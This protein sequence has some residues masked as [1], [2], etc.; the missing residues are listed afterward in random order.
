MPMSRRRVL[1]IVEC[2]VPCLRHWFREKRKRELDTRLRNNRNKRQVLINA[3]ANRRRCAKN[4]LNIAKQSANHGYREV[5][6]ANLTK[7]YSVQSQIPVMMKAIEVLVQ[8]E[9]RTERIRDQY[10]ITGALMESAELM[11]DTYE[12]C[13]G[14][15]YVT[16]AFGYINR[17]QDRA[18]DASEEFSNMLHGSTRDETEEM[19]LEEIKNKIDEF[20]G[21]FEQERSGHVSI[22]P[23]PL[24]EE[25]RTE[26]KQPS[27][28][29]PQGS[30]SH[31]H[32]QRTHA[33][34]SPPSRRPLPLLETAS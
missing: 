8:Q 15:E 29:Q 30:E 23:G 4:H 13:G 20:E 19:S 1:Q 26:S 17:V 21:E 34:A 12:E 11:E 2:V 32:R 33:V 18:R 25:K 6:Q 3:T 22:C 24:P 9:M 27:C 5:A 16:R 31:S 14:R 7:A 10:I 28:P